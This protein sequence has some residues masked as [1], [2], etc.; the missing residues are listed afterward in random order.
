MMSLH[1]S[2][3]SPEHMSHGSCLIILGSIAQKLHIHT[4]TVKGTHTRK[5]PRCLS[6]SGQPKHNCHTSDA[7][8]QTHT[9]TRYLEKK[10]ATTLT[11]NSESDQ[12]ILRQNTHS[13]VHTAT[14]LLLTPLFLTKK[15]ARTTLACRPC[16]SYAPESRTKPAATR[17]R[18][19]T[20]TPASITACRNF[21]AICHA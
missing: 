18:R 21:P 14:P 15:Q 10:N 9:Q 13:D 3:R 4:H 19:H 7:G 12:S 5:D 1:Q 17:G 6:A 2:T 16:A 20:P 11:N 8:H